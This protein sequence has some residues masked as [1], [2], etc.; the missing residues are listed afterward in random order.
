MRTDHI[1]TRFYPATPVARV[2][3]LAFGAVADQVNLPVPLAMTPAGHAH[4]IKITPARL[5]RNPIKRVGVVR[6]RAFNN[7]LFV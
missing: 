5:E 1:I 2:A 7:A 3:G 4:S 6:P